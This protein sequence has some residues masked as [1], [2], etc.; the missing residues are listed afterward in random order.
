[1]RL[2]ILRSVYRQLESLNMLYDGILPVTSC[3]RVSGSVFVRRVTVQVDICDFSVG[4]FRALTFVS[5]LYV[6][7]YCLR[8]N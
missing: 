6:I 2:I 1:M 8:C 4:Q 3:S 7:I 5:L